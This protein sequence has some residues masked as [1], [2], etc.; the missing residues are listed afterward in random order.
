M[1]ST[2]TYYAIEAKLLNKWRDDVWAWAIPRLASVAPNTT[3]GEFLA[4]FPNMPPK[5]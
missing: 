1:N 5:P 4:T 3:V 2:N